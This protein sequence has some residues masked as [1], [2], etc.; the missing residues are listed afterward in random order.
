MWSASRDIT[1]DEAYLALCGMTP[2]PAYF[3]GPPGVPLCV[4]FGTR[5]LDA[6]GLGAALLWPAFA[7]AASMAMYYLL[8]P[9][10]GSRSAVAL[11]LLLN[12]LP[13]FNRAA[14]VP[15]AAL[16]VTMLTLG[17]LAACWRALEN[18]SAFWWS[19]SG[20]CAAGGLLFAYSAAFMIPA[21][22]LVL[23]ASRRWRRELLAPGLWM[24][25]ALPVIVFAMLVTWNSNHGWVH[26]IGGTWQTALHFQ[27]LRLP[28]LLRVAVQGLSPLVTVAVVCGLLF[29]LRNIRVSPKAKFLCMPALMAFAFTAYSMLT[30]HAWASF[31]LIAAAL[32]VALI[33]W[34][35]GREECN[36]KHDR[37]AAAALQQILHIPHSPLFV[38]AVFLTAAVW[39]ALPMAHMA[40]RPPAV[41]PEL[42]AQIEIVRRSVSGNTPAFL[43]AEGAPLASAVA[44]YLDN[45]RGVP[46]GHPPVY[47]V[48]SPF[49]DSQFALWPRYD[50]FSEGSTPADLQNSQDPFTEQEGVNPFI[51]RSAVYI[52][53]QAPDDIPQAIT[54]AF[55][56]VRLLAEVSAPGGALY[57][58][59]LCSDYQTLPL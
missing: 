29:C 55:A 26:F 49:A 23:F 21:I 53:T 37:P 15:D 7:F 50:Q 36:R 24:A 4:A 19:I 38:P 52:T 48:E 51:G 18:S 5:T 25:A 56:S 59:Y 45:T 33:S 20:L 9:L 17:F 13:A 34:I 2:A 42:A 10:T 1:P 3:D 6:S 8:A 32:A 27:W 46:Q 31:G 16:P 39:T 47:V 43:V 11:A 35:A 12:F 41:S 14:L 58:L 28:A 54:A 40:S 44:L 57:R 22:I 30:G